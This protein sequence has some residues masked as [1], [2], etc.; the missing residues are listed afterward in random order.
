[1]DRV[2]R[3]P[4]KIGTEL[5]GALLLCS[6]PAVWLAELVVLGPL[7]LLVALLGTATL[8]NDSASHAFLPR[9]AV[10]SGLQP[11]HARI[12]STNAAAETACPALGGALLALISAPLAVLINVSTFLFSAIVVALIRV[13]EPRLPQVGTETSAPSPTRPL[14]PQPRQSPQPS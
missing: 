6:I 1:L 14:R 5:V 2:G 4:V 8:V 11:A 13:E 9:L 7:I 12:D 3:R 10:R